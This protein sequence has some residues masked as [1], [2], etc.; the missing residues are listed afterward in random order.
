MRKSTLITA[1]VSI[2]PI[3]TTPPVLAASPAS[4][5][6]CYAG[7]NAG[8]V[9]SEI[10]GTNLADGIYVFQDNDIGS[11]TATGGA[12]GGQLGCDYQLDNWVLGGRAAM[13]WTNAQGSHAFRDG[14]SPNNEVDYDLK[15]FGTLTARFGYLLREDTLGYLSGGFA[16]GRA[17]HTDSDPTPGGGWPPYTGSGELDRTGWTLGLGVE[18]RFQ[19][20]LTLFLA[21]DYVDFGEKNAYIDYDD[22]TSWRYE[23][24]QNM[25]ILSLGLNY[26]F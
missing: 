17:E 4:W 21:Y 8:Y 25:S 1:L 22:G 18:H 6:G 11:A 13:D 24:D 2:C 7:I 9:W 16:W 14:T 23:F 20:N 12:L 3:V 19:P 26:R 15:Y 5:T 10:S